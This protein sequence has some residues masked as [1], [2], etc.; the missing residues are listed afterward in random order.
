MLPN[1]GSFGLHQFLLDPQDAY[2]RM[3]FMTRIGHDMN[4]LHTAFLPI[5]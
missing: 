5:H 3:R 1:H 2:A 4:L